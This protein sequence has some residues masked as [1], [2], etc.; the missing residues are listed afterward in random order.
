[1]AKI[2][3]GCLCGNVRYQSS[4]EP[5]LQVVCHCKTCQKNSG[6]SFSTNIAVPSD[7]LSVTKGS[8]KTYDDHSGASGQ[9]FQRHFCPD[10]GSHIL[11]GGPA[12]GDLSFIKVG[13]LD[14]P[15]WVKPEIHLWCTEK[16]PWVE[17]PA[18]AKQFRGN[19]E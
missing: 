6:S 18:S 2:E 1:M 16:M 13:T 5:A 14:D 4:A 7:S 11:A 9:A 10:C 19:P 12:Y 15:S 3:G 17:I 8:V